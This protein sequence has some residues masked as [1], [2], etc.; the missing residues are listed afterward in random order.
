MK[1]LSTLCAALLVW[2]SATDGR[3]WDAAAKNIFAQE[4]EK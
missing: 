2:A 4:A 1:F 3:E